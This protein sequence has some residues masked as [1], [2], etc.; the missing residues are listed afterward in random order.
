[1]RVFTFASGGD[2][3]RPMKAT[4]WEFTNRAM[5]FG[6]IFG[7]SFPLYFLDRQNSTVALANWIG[8]RLQMDADLIARLLFALAALLLVL[9]AFIRTWASSYLHAAVVYAAEVKTA[10]LVADG[11][12]RQVRNPL[13]FANVL[14]A[15]ALGAM[16][17]RVGF[18]VALVAMLAFSYRLILRE[19]AELQANQGEP[20]QAY[21]R[22]VPRL[23]PAPWPRIASA[24]R[25]ANW[26]EGFK[27][28][29]WYWGFA[30]ALV[31][32]A[33][34]LKL[35]LFFVILA[36]SLVLFWVSSIVLQK[37]SNSQA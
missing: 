21:R 18:L 11:P 37:K 30:A 4:H 27:A 14:M 12:Y 15:I 16:M 32:F 10:S 2:I 20:Y 1:M 5:L 8:S 36:A 31:A 35:T 22:A 13:Y 33:I 7:V 17:S 19:E 28:E 29:S 6:L 25:Q 23:W 26:A 24:G 9:A 34:T 3:L